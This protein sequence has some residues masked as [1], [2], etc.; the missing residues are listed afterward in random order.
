[1]T[2]ETPAAFMERFVDRHHEQTLFETIVG[3]QD[4]ARL[5]TIS[6]GSGRGKSHLLKLLRIKCQWGPN[7]LPVSLVAL[8]QLQHMTTYEF[9]FIVEAALREQ[10]LSFPTFARYET[11]RKWLHGAPIGE[12]DAGRIESGSKVGGVYLDQGATATFYGASLPEDVQER[13]R[14]DA[15]LGFIDDLRT[16]CEH[17][18][19]VLL[20][21][22]YEKCSGQLNQFLPSL[23]RTYA[24]PERRIRNLVIVIA[25]REVPPLQMMFASDYDRVVRAVEALSV[26]QREHVER[27]L[28]LNLGTYTEADVEL[29]LDKLQKKEWTIGNTANFTKLFADREE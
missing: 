22:A 27:F 29:V 13:L 2:V 6:D 21:D 23:L 24:D 7:P 9:V 12:V 10:G 17:E 18:R 14:Q 19:V 26:W 3:C 5:L 8:D 25:G 28:E 4:E 1:M 16:L 15:V 20:I 11:E